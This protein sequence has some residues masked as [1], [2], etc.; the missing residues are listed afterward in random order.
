M[1][2]SRYSWWPEHRKDLDKRLTKIAH[3][4]FHGST[5]TGKTYLAYWLAEH[6]VM[7]G[8][9]KFC[10]LWRTDL[11]RLEEFLA[12][13]LPHKMSPK[14][15]R[16]YKTYKPIDWLRETEV[17]LYVPM[18]AGM[19][20]QDSEENP[21]PLKF[22]NNDRVKTFL[23]TV[24][25]D[26]LTSGA[27]QI[28]Y[29]A[30]D[31]DAAFQK[32]EDINYK[33]IT[34]PQLM[35]RLS[36]S[37]FQKVN[38]RARGLGDSIGAVKFSGSGAYAT[39][40]SLLEKLNA[41]VNE[42]LMGNS[43]M[44]TSLPAIFKRN[45]EW[46][47]QKS[48]VGLYLGHIKDPRLRIFALIS[49]I[50]Y[51]KRFT[52]SLK[53]KV[54]F[55]VV[56]YINE[57]SILCPRQS[58]KAYRDVHTAVTAFM[59]NWVPQARHSNIEIWADT[60][61]FQSIDSTVLSQFT[62]KYLTRY[63]LSDIKAMETFSTIF[64]IELKSLKNVWADWQKRGL[65]RFFRA[66]VYNQLYN[67]ASGKLTTGFELPRPKLSFDGKVS[68]SEFDL[69]SFAYLWDDYKDVVAKEFEELKAQIKDDIERAKK[70]KAKDSM[71][72]QGAARKAID[73]LGYD[74]T[75][76]ASIKNKNQLDETLKQIQD[77]AEEVL[78]TEVS[79]ASVK[80]AVGLW[81]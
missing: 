17:H 34:F 70:Q 20:K 23:F 27:I 50:D 47:Q 53:N 13:A 63:D 73:I 42:G 9:I 68:L 29:G 7:E 80:R 79:M 64:D 51:Q 6:G 43:S 26:D 31:A 59:T 32:Y 61:T 12:L 48:I 57:L 71:T 39:T 28:L 77:K 25:C 33:N 44:D 19:M 69:E 54:D 62:T 41:F 38:L 3:T 11:D 30:A 72:Q 81:K 2:H 45:R 4:F 74:P 52:G 15:Y 10:D 37:R 60:Q 67:E 24:P 56:N 49:F 16:N 65:H 14:I 18:T 40:T 35:H 46:R 76:V 1:L 55:K 58:G 5:T 8:K 22:P 21:F 75:Q 78:E 66:G 36:K